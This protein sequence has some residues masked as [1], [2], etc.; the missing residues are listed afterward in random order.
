VKALL[1]IAAGLLM[2]YSFWPYAQDIMSGRAKPARSVRLMLVALLLIIF[3]QQ[4]ALHSGWGSLMVGCEC[5]GSLAILLLSLKRGV[6]GLH[7][8]D[9]VCYVL[10]AV[11]VL[12]WLTTHD[13]FLAIQL[14]IL[15]D[16]IAFTPT[17]VKTW[18]HPWTETP[19]FF[20]L[21][22][23]A[24]ALSAIS[25]SRYTFAILLFPI[26]C[27][28]IH[29]VELGLIIVRQRIAPLKSNLLN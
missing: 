9:V 20:L 5:L 18:R 10:L 24:A 27:I 11:D 13:A 15:A 23:I 16:I 8:I 22:G 3:L 12:L 6:G 14:T 4:R 2:L 1:S 21:G 19:L 25:V 28:L 26:Y 17:L 7:T 29:A